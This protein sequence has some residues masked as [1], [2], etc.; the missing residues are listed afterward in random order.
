MR[1]APGASAN[2][3][4]L[5]REHASL[6]SCQVRELTVRTRIPQR[7]GTQELDF[8]S[9]LPPS[10]NLLLSPVPS[11]RAK[12]VCRVLRRISSSRLTHLT[13]SHQPED[14]RRG[15]QRV[16]KFSKVSNSTAGPPFS[17]TSPSTT[18]TTTFLYIY[19]YVP[20]ATAMRRLG[21]C[22]ALHHVPVAPSRCIRYIIA[23]QGGEKGY[24]GGLRLGSAK[25]RT[26]A[27]TWHL[28]DWE[29]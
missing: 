12:T 24:L 27:S 10:S 7:R 9:I 23:R 8:L 19:M 11:T 6:G 25:K 18:S 1:N 17:P 22:A 26:R 2:G 28:A 5:G 16:G 3:H 29:I 15:Q 21:I 14:C 4:F 20:S 13:G